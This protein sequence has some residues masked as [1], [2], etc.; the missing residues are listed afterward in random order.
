MQPYRKLTR[1]IMAS[2]LSQVGEVT[3]SSSQVHEHARLQHLGEEVSGMATVTGT[4]A[5]GTLNPISQDASSFFHQSTSGTE[6]V[7]VLQV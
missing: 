7:N 5:G 6:G 2:S 4:E 3:V 1:D